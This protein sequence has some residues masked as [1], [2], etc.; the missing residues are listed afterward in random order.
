M[1]TSNMMLR[2]ILLLI[3]TCQNTINTFTTGITQYNNASSINKIKNLIQSLYI[4][5]SSFQ[6]T[7]H[8]TSHQCGTNN[9]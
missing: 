4:T 1:N 3:I 2:L 9:R 5:P 7:I 8:P 6:E